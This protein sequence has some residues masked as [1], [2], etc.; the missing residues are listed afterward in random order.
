MDGSRIDQIAKVFAQRK[1]SRRAVV[2]KG[3][4]AAVAGAIAATGLGASVFAQEATPAAEAD[5]VQYLF[6]QS[7]Q[8]GKIEPK[9]G[10]DGTYTL[11]LEQG[12]GQTIYFSDRPERV[13]G[14]APTK[15]FL[16]GLG[17]PADN[18]PNAALV[19][20]AAPGDTDI[21]VLELANPRYD[22]ASHTAT[23][24]VQFLEHYE[25]ALEM[26]FA[27]QPTDLAQLH[28][29]FGAAHLFIDDCADGKVSCTTFNRNDTCP[30]GVG[31]IVCGVLGPMGYC[32]NWSTFLCTPCEPYW[33]TNPDFAGI[34]NYWRLTCDNLFTQ[35][36]TIKG[37]DVW[38]TD[39][40]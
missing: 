29:Q 2:A 30:D 3:S 24:D 26:T 21:A 1:V 37:C 27:E 10:E 40:P 7:F 39:V 33:H 19:V 9:A 16:D 11:T 20:E 4:T 32:W 34:V 17:F 13:V 23:Y 12:L 22:E 15:V 36:V 35:C 38:F 14:A 6:V 5:K 8:S 18:P 28:P 25:Q 31:G